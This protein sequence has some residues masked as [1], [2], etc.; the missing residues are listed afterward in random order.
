MNPQHLLP[1]YWRAALT[2]RIRFIS[3]LDDVDLYLL[4]EYEGGPDMA[5]AAVL[6][7]HDTKEFRRCETVSPWYVTVDGGVLASYGSQFSYSTPKHV[8]DVIA[9]YHNLTS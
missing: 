6:P 1:S 8:Y 5:Y 2:G 9:A 3:R 4:A 7:D